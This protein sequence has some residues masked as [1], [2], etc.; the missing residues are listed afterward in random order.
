MCNL[1]GEEVMQFHT[2]V[3]S[4]SSRKVLAV[5]NHL[6]LSPDIEYHDFF[7]GD[8]RR[9]GY[10]ALNSNAKVPVLK[11]GDFVLWESNAIMQYLADK[12]GDTALFPRDPRTRADIARWQCWELAHF[13]KAFGVIFFESVAKPR[14]G[15][16][17]PNA[18]LVASALDDLKR[19]A[20]V[21]ERHLAGRKYIVGDDITI[22]D[23]SVIHLEHYQSAIDFDWTP[24][25]NVN[26]YYERMRNVE[27]WRKTA[28]ARPEDIGRKP[29]AA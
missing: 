16:G 28:P 25:P 26:A 15:L 14:F 21:L 6:G 24:Y 7:N 29:K 10:L 1:W 17:E 22:A 4:P 5:I 2:V 8:L 13:N 11:D 18:A 12:A 3:G 27:H 20:P 19:Y 9:S 23:Y